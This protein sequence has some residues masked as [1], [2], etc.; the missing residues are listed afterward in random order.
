MP[1]KHIAAHLKKTELAC[2]LHYHQMSYGNNGRRRTDSISSTVSL[3]SVATSQQD[4]PENNLHHTQ[5]SPVTSPPRSPGIGSQKW[6]APDDKISSQQQHRAHVPIL[7]KQDA[8][9]TPLLPRLDTY[10]TQAAAHNSRETDKP[11]SDYSRVRE[12]YE[13][14]RESFWSMIA[15]EYSHEFRVSAHAI[16]HAFFQSLSLGLGR[17]HSLPTPRPSP[18][19]SPKPQSHGY[20]G[21]TVYHRG[22][23]AVNSVSASTSSSSPSIKT[24]SSADR[25]SVYALLTEEREVRPSRGQLQSV[26]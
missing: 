7:P 6:G 25:C 14:H 17:E 26:K 18:V 20:H 2:R 22:F 8:R 16:E 15:A 13:A 1:Y 4:M 10:L 5:L 23:Q 3:N 24:P 9:Y 19:A 12:L 11:V 21:S